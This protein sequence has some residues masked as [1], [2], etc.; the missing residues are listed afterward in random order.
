MPPVHG[1]TLVELLVV[2]AIIGVLVAL[3]LPAVQ[4]AR[5]AARRIQC[6]N[7]L[8]QIGLALNSYHDGHGVLPFACGYSIAQ[9]GTWVSFI[10]PNLEQQAIYD[11]L[12]FN[13]PLSHPNNVVPVTQMP[14]SWIVC[15]SDRSAGETTMPCSCLRSEF[16]PDPSM[17]LW[18]PT[19]MGPTEPDRCPFCPPE[20][21]RSSDP[22]CC[23]SSSYGSVYPNNLTV[24]M[25]GRYPLGI[26]YGDV[27]DGLAY[28]IAAGETLPDQCI[29]NGAYANNFPI[30]GTSIPINTFEVCDVAGGP[31]YRACGYKSMHPGGANFMMGDGSVHFFEE[32]I[33]YKLYNDLG[34]R[35]GG[36]VVSLP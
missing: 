10:L 35:D 2:I 17:K 32:F 3:L 1:F 13:L 31:H 7:H 25:F 22:W 36:E 28:T 26:K 29:Y 12:D 27:T 16:N 20:V 18:Y 5:E 34:T 9:T 8:K 14:I 33:D 6:S 11:L 23:E 19:C 30:A 21:I 24:G 4:A 15:P